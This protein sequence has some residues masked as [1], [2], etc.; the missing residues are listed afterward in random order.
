MHARI[1]HLLSLRDGEPVAAA[2][3]EHV[4]LCPICSGELQRLSAIRAEIQELPQFEPPEV[5]ERLIDS[6]ATSGK[7]VADLMTGHHPEIS[8]E[9]LAMSRYAKAPGQRVSPRPAA[10][11]A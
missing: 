4:K 8:I 3:A 11:H 2:V 10:G 9:G 1:E 5:L 7:L 6:G